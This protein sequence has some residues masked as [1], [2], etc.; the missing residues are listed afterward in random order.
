MAGRAGRANSGAGDSFLLVDA[1]KQA[2]AQQF[3]GASL[4]SAQSTLT[5]ERHGLASLMLDGI[6]SSLC[7]NREALTR[8]VCSTLL[9]HALC[10]SV[11]DAASDPD[12]GL[13]RSALA[14]QQLLQDNEFIEWR[15]TTVVASKLG[16]AAFASGLM[17]NDALIVFSSLSQTLDYIRL[18]DDLHVVYLVTPVNL[19]LY[20]S[21]EHFLAWFQRAAP[22]ALQIAHTLGIEVSLPLHK[23]HPDSF[24]ILVTNESGCDY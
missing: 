5:L 23:S 7:S 2:L 19:S 24:V 12:S 13:W 6:A 18:D 1:G 8:L 14:A 21:W 3:L 9:R 16:L 11:Y 10:T 17:P 4:P 15:D 22:P 20:P